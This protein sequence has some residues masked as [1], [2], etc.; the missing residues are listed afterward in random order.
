MTAAAETVVGGVHAVDVAVGLGV[1][2]LEDRDSL[3]VVPVRHGLLADE[4]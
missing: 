4:V 3:L 1:E 2:L